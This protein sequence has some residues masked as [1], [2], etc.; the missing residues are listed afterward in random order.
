MSWTNQDVPGQMFFLS[1]FLGLTLAFPC[2]ACDCILAG[3]RGFLCMGR[4]GCLDGGK[5]SAR[6]LLPQD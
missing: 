3:L 5:G 4:D 6:W 1:L 2:L